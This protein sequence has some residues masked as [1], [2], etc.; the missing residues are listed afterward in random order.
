MSSLLTKSF[1][2]FSS[3]WTVERSRRYLRGLSVAYIVIEDA[4]LGFF[5]FDLEAFD[6]IFRRSLRDESLRV[7]LDL[8]SRTRAQ[9]WQTGDITSD[10]PANSVAMEDDVVVG[11]VSLND[12]GDEVLRSGLKSSP[13]HERVQSR[14]RFSA[15][16][17]LIVPPS[18]QNGQRIEVIV[19]FS[20]DPDGQ[21]RNVEKVSIESDET[22]KQECLVI[23]TPQGLD[24]DRA[25]ALLP[26]DDHATVKFNGQ[27]IAGAVDV[28]IKVQ[29]LWKN[30]IIAIAHASLPLSGAAAATTNGLSAKVANPCRAQIPDGNGQVDLTVTAIHLGEGQVQWTLAS[31]FLPELCRRQ[32]APIPCKGTREFA[33]DILYRMTAAQ[34]GFPSAA[35]NVLSAIGSDIRY[36]MPDELF[37]ALEKIMGAYSSEAVP[38]I[39]LLTDDPYIPWEFAYVDN[40]LD[41]TAQPYLHTQ[42]NM[43]RW[44][45]NPHVVLPPSA[46]LDVSRL[47]VIASKYGYGTGYKE[48][49]EAIVER[50]WLSSQWAVHIIEAKRD[51]LKS[52]FEGA[53][54]PGHWIHFA[55]HGSSDVEAN[56]H[57]LVLADRT[58]LIPQMLTGRYRCREI[59]RVSFAFI[60][61][62]QT[63]IPGS[64][65]GQASGFPG[66]LV[67]GGAIGV[68]APFWSIHDRKAR[69][70]ATGFYEMALQNS[71]SEPVGATLRKLRNEYEK[72]DST[73]ALS[74]L[75]Y[76]HPMLRLRDTIA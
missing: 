36:R 9:I 19:G 27:H 14:N 60:N 6:E 32:I 57:K 58:P 25:W 29:F 35:D 67:K 10:T 13:Q 21:K 45:E 5:V 48:L 30:E 16:P 40:L 75:Y 8:S 74:Y 4:M 71:P 41:K 11:V 76:G 20:P 49:P 66:E 63:G 62:C 54:V 12:S 7:A 3:E 64:S 69:E 34:S 55:L 61:A 68:I 50:D 31:R 53:V 28:S 2:R 42:T 72:G 56:E 51:D 33:K 24:L 1:V 23:A 73:T 52:L 26:L 39:L 59:P 18:I 70:Y 47:T 44:V 22:E 15:Y 38:S 17:L 37:E 65:L 46:T 43:E